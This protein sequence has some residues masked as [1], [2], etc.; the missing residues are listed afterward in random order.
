MPHA[1]GA[2]VAGGTAHVTSFSP[3]STRGQQELPGRAQPSPRERRTRPAG[4]AAGTDWGPRGERDP[5]RC[6]HVR[7]LTAC[8][9]ALLLPGRELLLAV[10]V[11][12]GWILHGQGPEA[13]AA[14]SAPAAPP[15]GARGWGSTG[16]GG[17]H[18][19][20][21][22]RTRCKRWTRRALGSPRHPSLCLQWDAARWQ[23]E[24]AMLR[25]S[26]EAVR[27]EREVAEQDLEALL[28]SHQ[29]EMQAWRQH[30]QQ[31]GREGWAPSPGCW[32]HPRRVPWGPGCPRRCFRSSGAR[33]RS[34]QRHWSTGTGRCCRRCCGMSWSF[35]HTISGCGKPKV[36]AQLMPP[37]RHPETA[38]LNEGH[39]CPDKDSMATPRPLLPGDTVTTAT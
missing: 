2:A 30:L 31:V 5:A 10:P 38:S 16:P 22:G 32:H 33:R 7:H 39:S 11:P 14:G 21:P 18:R 37:R 8:P 15:A 1:W 3:K 24:V 6:P 9:T 4:G 34:G 35:L 25:L 20:A 23:Q 28:Q 26:L 12:G 13:A 36:M 27:R 19:R 17:E 29:Q